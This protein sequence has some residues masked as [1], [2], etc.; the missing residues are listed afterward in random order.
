MKKILILGMLL[1]ATMTFANS[2]SSSEIIHSNSNKFKE[3]TQN[4][5]L[6]KLVKL[7]N[8]TINDKKSKK[9][10]K[11]GDCTLTVKGT[12]DGHKV[13]VIVTIS[14]VS[15]VKCTAMKA[16]ILAAS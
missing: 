11:M 7:K 6:N 4:V 10:G 1:S 3:N 14:D 15:W 2:N 16:G 9:G 12:F 5:S 8:A 13:D